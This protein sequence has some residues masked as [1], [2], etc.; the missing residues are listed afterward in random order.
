[1]IL[2][3]ARFGEVRVEPDAII[4]FAQPIIGF[5]LQRHFVLLPGPKD[6]PLKWLQ[7]LDSPELAFLVLDPRVIVPDY[8]ISLSPPELAEL[9]AASV[10]ELDIYTLL[11]VPDD[12]SQVRTNLRAPVLVNP[13]RRLARQTVLD[14]GDY[15]IQFFLAQ[16][17]QGPEAREKSHARADA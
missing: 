1:M 5:A 14:R 15:P 17:K 7:S 3:T 9:E 8:K 6:G 16:A 11:V 4:T 10:E 13:K 12:P 2:Q